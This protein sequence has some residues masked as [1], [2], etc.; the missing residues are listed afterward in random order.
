MPAVFKEL[1]HTNGYMTIALLRLK[2][3]FLNLV[4]PH[5]VPGY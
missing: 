3:H 2:L 5:T 4:D 1:L